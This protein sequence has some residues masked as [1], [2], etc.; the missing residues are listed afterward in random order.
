[1][2]HFLK[3][4]KTQ[5]HYINKAGHN[6]FRFQEDYELNE[7]QIQFIED[8]KEYLKYVAGECDNVDSVVNYL[9]DLMACYVQ[10]YKTESIL[11]IVGYYGCG[12][13]FLHKLINLLLDKKYQKITKEMLL[14]YNSKLKGKNMWCIR[15]NRRK[16]RNIKRWRKQSDISKFERLDR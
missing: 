2:K 16:Q 13:S 8:I 10:G 12:K 3:M 11:F 6:K 7:T 14:K 15:R 4:K 1:M 5:I 9:F